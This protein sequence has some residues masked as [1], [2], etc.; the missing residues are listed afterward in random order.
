MLFKNGQEGCSEISKLYW[1]CQF[2][3]DFIC[4]ENIR[5]KKLRSYVARLRCSNHSLGIEIHRYTKIESDKYCKFCMENDNYIVEDE[6]HFV[7]ECNA[8]NNLREQYIP[9][10]YF[11]HHSDINYVKLMSS[12]SYIVLNNSAVYIR[13]AVILRN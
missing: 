8:Y 7:I 6:K 4:L 2:K 11:N 12:D 1:Y 13:K 5:D 9:R 10:K 3:T